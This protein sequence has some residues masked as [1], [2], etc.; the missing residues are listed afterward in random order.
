MGPGRSRKTIDQMTG[1][2]ILDSL[3]RGLDK[4]TRWPKL[5]DA[6]ELD[7]G[8]GPPGALLLND[9]FERRGLGRP[10]PE[11]MRD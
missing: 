2:E 7:P 11:R 8:A 3:G 6:L 9:A 1:D 5:Y 4:G 10:L